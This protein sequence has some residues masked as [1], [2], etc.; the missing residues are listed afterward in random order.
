[1][2]Y[3][4][5]ISD[6]D[7]LIELDQQIKRLVSDSESEKDTRKR[8]NTSFDEKIEKLNERI[9]QINMANLGNKISLGNIERLG[10]VI[11]AG[12]VG[13]ITSLFSRGH[14]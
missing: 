12:I 11:V 1:M 6:H 13:W 14:P 7:K 8:R 2:T 5:S 9:D 10:W 4:M 3:S